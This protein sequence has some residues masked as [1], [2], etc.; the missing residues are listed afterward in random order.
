MTTSKAWNFVV[1]LKPKLVHLDNLLPLV[2]ELTAAG[3]VGRLLFVAPNPQTFAVIQE[4]VVLFDGIGFCGG[5]LVC[6]AKNK[7]R[8]LNLCRNLFMLHCYLLRPCATVFSAESHGRLVQMLVTFNRRYLGGKLFLS[9]LSNAPSAVRKIMYE[10]ARV[11]TGIDAAERRKDL[12]VNAIEAE[13]H[14]NS[15]VKEQTR[16][17]ARCSDGILV[18]DELQIGESVHTLTIEPG[19]RLLNV[20]NP[21]QLPA[22]QRHLSDNARRYLPSTVEECYFFYAL[23]VLDL[24]NPERENRHDL[25][26]VRGCLQVLCDYNSDIMTVF[27]PHPT[28]DLKKLDNLLQ[29]LHYENYEIC[30]VHPMILA[31]GAKFTLANYSSTVLVDA[32]NLGCPTIDYVRYDSRGLEV[33]QGRSML[34][35]YV[36][37]FVPGDTALFREVLDHLIHGAE[38]ARAPSTPTQAFKSSTETALPNLTKEFASI[39]NATSAS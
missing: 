10:L 38:I 37:F 22:W 5:R 4:N 24:P 30:N 1:F 13:K 23:G 18:G 11:T 34:L 25:E 21:R 28:T 33:L 2:M 3:F 19:M 32:H 27:K 35:D 20:G 15:Y 36:D 9:H 26:S 17:A 7:S 6:L 12:D 31:K 8:I 14:H 16:R 39:L 29:E